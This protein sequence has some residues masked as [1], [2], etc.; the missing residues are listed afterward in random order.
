MERHESTYDLILCGDT[1]NYFG[2]L[3]DIMQLAAGQ[4]EAAGRFVF[5]LEAAEQTLQA[6][7]DLGAHGRYIHNRAYVERVLEAAEL[8]VESFASVIL[9]KDGGKPVEGFLI[10]VQRSSS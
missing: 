2:R 1:L 3:D 6:D 9:R 4:L 7:Y 5:T 8:A 10:Q